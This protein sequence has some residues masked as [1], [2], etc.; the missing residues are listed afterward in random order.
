MRKNTNDICSRMSYDPPI[1]KANADPHTHRLAHAHRL[2]HM[3]SQY[4]A[5][6]SP[7]LRF[8]SILMHMRE[9]TPLCR[10][11][12]VCVRVCVC[13]YACACVCVCVPVRMCACVEKRERERERERLITD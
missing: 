12:R 2:A 8:A 1:E 9:Q 4:L 7:K 13:E 11:V 10:G 3:H 5:P 6:V